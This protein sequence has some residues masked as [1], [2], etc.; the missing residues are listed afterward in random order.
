MK[1]NLGIILLFLGILLISNTASASFC[2]WIWPYPEQCPFV[3][4]KPYYPVVHLAVNELNNV[5]QK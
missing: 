2:F 4:P 1:K 3:Q 5:I